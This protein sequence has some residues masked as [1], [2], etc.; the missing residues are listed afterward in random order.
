MKGLRRDFRRKA[1][2]SLII[3]QT[4]KIKEKN[5]ETKVR[6]YFRRSVS[7]KCISIYTGIEQII[8]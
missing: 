1:H 3:L 4:W 6:A 2:L 8:W 7:G 5:L